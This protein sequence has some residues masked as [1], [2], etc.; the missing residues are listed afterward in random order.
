M[1]FVSD[2]LFDEHWIGVL[3]IVENVTRDCLPLDASSRVCWLD[4]LGVLE[5]SHRC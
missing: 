3:V 1:D 5:S 4:V 2:Q